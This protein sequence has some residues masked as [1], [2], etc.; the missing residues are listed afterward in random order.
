[1]IE[2]PVIAE[3]TI[4][5]EFVSLLRV[6]ANGNRLRILSLLTRQE[7]CV[8]EIIETLGLSQSL[9]SHHLGVLRRSG[10]VQDRQEG[11]WVYYSIDGGSLAKLNARY[12]AVLD[13]AELPPEAAY[14]AA[15]HRCD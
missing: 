11:H 5:G 1:M 9:I 6:I 12:R 10:L 3:E 15:P 7:M 8:C 4:S 2:A 13:V 14:G